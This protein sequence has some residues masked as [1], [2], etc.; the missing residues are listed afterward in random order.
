MK[1]AANGVP[2]L[3]TLDGWW[4]EGCIE[5][6]TGWAIGANDTQ[7]GEEEVRSMYDKLE[8]VILPLYYK[9]RD[10][11]IDVM[12]GAMALNGSFFNTE[13]M[14]NQYIAKAYFK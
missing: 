6:M 13:R 3:S 11:F 10:R 4:I 14:L 2:S 8:H 12:R 5:G 9:E 1:A 7:P